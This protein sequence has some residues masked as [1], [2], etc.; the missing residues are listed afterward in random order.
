MKPLVPL[1]LAACALLGLWLPAAH[2]IDSEPPFA[3]PAMQQ[4]YERLI[5]EFRC[6][7]CFDESIA[8]SNADLAADFRREVHAMIAAGKSDR[9]IRDFMVR[10]YGDFILY[11]PP[12]Q[13]NTWLLWG[14]PFLL[15]AVALAVVVRVVYRRAHMAQAERGSGS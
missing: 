2:A 9:Q 4:R 12:L 1:L 8:D 11:D 3:D 15:F 6:L 13:P 14:G 5:H 7:V 10:R